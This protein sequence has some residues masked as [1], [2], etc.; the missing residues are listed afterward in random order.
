MTVQGVHDPWI[1]TGHFPPL[2][3]Q[4]V[5]QGGKSKPWALR[6]VPGDVQLNS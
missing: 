2:A 1:P 6:Q 4:G 5:D 3:G